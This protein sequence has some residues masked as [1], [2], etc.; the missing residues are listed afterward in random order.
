MNLSIQPEH[1]SIPVQQESWYSALIPSKGYIVVPILLYI[2]ILVFIIALTRGANIL[3]P[4]VAILI[5]LGA[6]LRRLTLDGEPWRL[7]TSLFIHIGIIHLVLNLLA[8]IMIGKQLERVIGSFNFAAFYIFTGLIASLTSVI[9][10]VN[11]ASAGA[12][13]AI[14]GMFGLFIGLLLSKTIHF[15]DRKSLLI[16]MSILVGY[17]LIIGMKQGIDNAAHAGGLV[18]GILVGM[19]AGSYMVEEDRNKINYTLLGSCAAF[20]I[21]ICWIGLAMT[22]N[23]MKIYE[24]RLQLFDTRE[25]EALAILRLDAST[26]KDE[27]E[28]QLIDRGVYYWQEN[29]DMLKKMEALNL[30]AEF[31]T[32][33]QNLIK[34]CELRIDSYRLLSKSIV[35]ETK[36]Y[37][38]DIDRYNTQIE[39]LLKSLKPQT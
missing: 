12:S 15:E 26:S 23:T 39:E 32:Y 21:V 38:Q 20:T 1:E 37:D 31:N 36:K 7:F 22:T 13:G 27:I 10:H 5:D 33:N 18:S 28:Y 25:K 17:N 35:E 11:T 3:S 9:W 8:L 16:N 2:N 14:F 34:Y 4:D 19:L 24:E 6:N 30:P 29:I